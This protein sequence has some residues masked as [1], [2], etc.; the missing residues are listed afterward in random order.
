M[1]Q[2]TT[3]WVVWVRVLVD[4]TAAAR[5]FSLEGLEFPAKQP[6]PVE[7]EMYGTIPGDSNIQPGKFWVVTEDALMRIC[8]A[9]QE[10]AQGTDWFFP[11]EFCEP[12]SRPQG[13][14]PTQTRDATA[15]ERSEGLE[16]FQAVQ[17]QLAKKV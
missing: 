17:R 4:P 12:V 5:G 7:D 11:V 2:D 16:T 9:M 1:T 6:Q 13:V 3:N 8:P 15:E 14:E 10:F